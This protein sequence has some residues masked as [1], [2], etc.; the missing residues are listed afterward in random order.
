MY[1]H[2]HITDA[3]LVNWALQVG[4]RFKLKDV[5]VYAALDIMDRYMVLQAERFSAVPTFLPQDSLEAAARGSAS[6]RLVVVACLS[7]ASKLFTQPHTRSI[8]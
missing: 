1:H 4:Q 7:I 8:K 2:A 5:T 6:T 3:A